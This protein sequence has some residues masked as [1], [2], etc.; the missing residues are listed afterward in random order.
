MESDCLSMLREPPS[1]TRLSKSWSESEG[2]SLLSKKPPVSLPSGSPRL[3]LLTCTEAS[4]LKLRPGIETK[5][6]A[7]EAVESQAVRLLAKLFDWVQLEPREEV[8]G[9]D[10]SNSHLFWSPSGCTKS[11]NFEG[12]KHCCPD[13]Y[14]AVLLT[15]LDNVADAKDGALAAAAC[16]QL[17]AFPGGWVV[18]R[19]YQ[20]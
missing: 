14:V 17:L 5:P 9:N 13:V 6:G 1:W 3:K 12:F 4:L 15:L 10:G 16:D 8:H 19:S 18:G 20:V 11:E 7:A 2:L